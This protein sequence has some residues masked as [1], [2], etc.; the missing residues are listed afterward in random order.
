MLYGEWKYLLST[1][2]SS[3]LWTIFCEFY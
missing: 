2:T 3:L 1:V